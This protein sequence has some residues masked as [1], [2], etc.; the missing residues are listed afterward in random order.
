MFFSVNFIFCVLRWNFTVTF[1]LNQNGPWI[2]FI[3]HLPLVTRS[4][5]GKKNHSTHS[6]KINLLK[7]FSWV[8]NTV[9]LFWWFFFYHRF[10]LP[11][12]FSSVSRNSKNNWLRLTKISL[13]RIN[14]KKQKIYCNGWLEKIYFKIKKRSKLIF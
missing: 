12:G 4:V 11:F 5:I 6:L 13:Q 3:V 7:Y 9:T 2:F 14:L 8:T 10:V 1:S